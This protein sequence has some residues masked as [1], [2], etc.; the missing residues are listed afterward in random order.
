MKKWMGKKDNNR[1]KYVEGTPPFD[2]QSQLRRSLDGVMG[3]GA[4]RLSGVSRVS[5]SLGGFSSSMPFF[6]LP[7]AFFGDLVGEP[8]SPPRGGPSRTEVYGQASST[9][10]ATQVRRHSWTE[11]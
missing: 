1:R 3:P 10:A 8:G 6:G 2:I 9:A 7:G 11:E 4:G 5:S